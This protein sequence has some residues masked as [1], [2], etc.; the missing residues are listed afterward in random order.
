MTTRR[1]LAVLIAERGS[2]TP[3]EIVTAA[4]DTLPVLFVLDESAAGPDDDRLR[5]VAEALAPTVYADFADVEG[6][7][8]AIAAAGATAVTTFTDRLCPLAARIRRRLQP[9]GGHE[10][11]SHKEEQRR[12]L[13][14]AGV[15]RVRSTVLEQPEQA[16][17]LLARWGS[18]VVVKPVNGVASAHTWL[19]RSPEDVDAF[20]A[21]LGHRE[22][23]PQLFA[24]QFITGLPRETPRLADYVSVEVIRPATGTAPRLAFV[25]DRAPPA[26]PCRETGLMWPTSLPEPAVAR[27]VATAGDALEALPAG[28][29]SYHVEIKPGPD[30]DEIIEVNGRLGGFVA[31]AAAYG[32]DL[33]VARLALEVAAGPTDRRPLTI[34]WRRCVAVLL[35]PAPQAARRISR[36]PDR[37]TLSRR[38]GVL[39]VDE[40]RGEG[41]PCS[42]QRGTDDAVATLWLAGDSHRRLWDRFLDLAEYL[43]TTFAFVDSERK[44]VADQGW[45]ERLRDTDA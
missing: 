25:T 28:P 12:R 18:G 38:P 9:A 7:A 41:E 43:H 4:G 44:P 10:L 22:G 16:R 34:T 1:P 19:L 5:L 26:A 45:L 14:A 17:T 11:W 23:G 42:W 6:C 27:L 15:S 40:V 8:D 30:H 13:V 20:T 36:A 29:G 31:R 32:A 2:L 39:A 3:V 21:A 33:D 37:R 24:E 35:F